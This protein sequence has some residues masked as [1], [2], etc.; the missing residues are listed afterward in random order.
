MKRIVLA[1][2]NEGKVKEFKKILADY[3]ILSMKEMGLDIDIEETG[4]T[5]YE[6]ALLKAKTVSEILHEDVI[7]DDS[8]L[9]VD[10]LNGA[11]GVYS[12]RYSGGTPLDNMIKLLKELDGVENRNAQFCSS[13]VLYKKDGT[14]IEGFGET[15]G[16]IMHEITGDNGFGYDPIFYS[17]DLKKSFGEATDEEKNSVSHRGRAI[18]DLVKKL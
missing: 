3:E 12:A 14:I 8:G 17:L 7:A 2:G 16:Y 10:A 13:V 4:T 18:E 11:P 6:N 9:C 1:S 15:K 5:Y